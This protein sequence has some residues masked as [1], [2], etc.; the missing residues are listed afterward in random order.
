VPG[1]ERGDWREVDRRLDKRFGAAPTDGVI[2][3]VGPARFGGAISPISTEELALLDPPD[4]AERIGG[5]EPP[6][7]RSFL[8]PSAE[9]LANALTELISGNAESWLEADPGKIVADLGAPRYVSAY[10]E[11][12]EKVVDR[13]ER[14]QAELLVK[15]VADIQ[16]VS[17]AAF[18]DDRG[19]ANDWVGA[20]HRGNRLIRVLKEHGLLEQ[21]NLELAWEA[22]V[23]AV[24]F[25]G[26]GS[27]GDG[28]PLSRAINRPWSSALETAILL[29][30]RDGSADPRLLELFEEILGLEGDDAELGRAI[31]ATRLP[32]IRHVA[33]EW[34]AD[35]E[36]TLIGK[37][38]PDHL[39]DL[40]F[41]IYL[42]WGRPAETILIEQRER[43]IGSLQGSKAEF[44]LRHLLHGLAWGVEGFSPADVADILTGFPELFNE[45]A[46][47]LGIELRELDGPSAEFDRAI[48]L[49]R[50]ALARE[51]PAEAYSG[52]GWFAIN[53]HLEDST[54]LDL[55][56]QTAERE[57]VNLA[58]PEEIAERGER[59]PPDPR[60]L[61]LISLLLDADPKAWEL[62]Q[63]GA[64]GLR[65]LQSGTG[66]Q[67]VRDEL[68]ERLLERG[69]HDARGIP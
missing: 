23:A 33:P 3:R 27:G 45:A 54:W 64:A 14:G 20:A 60:V 44:A 37:Q 63:I 34:F 53:D 46:R 19:D 47:E 36:G 41:A 40:T 67:E 24:R 57:D 32:W 59:L 42:E 10:L 18:G 49:W 11:G 30:D 50:E 21:E 29:A 9:G 51:L 66:D 65:L 55:T 2:F 16:S 26:P 4:A 35:N 15:A 43:L 7:E 38:A 12:M 69:F 17:E 58:E 6:P 61:R 25:R 31:I 48:D 39:G 8:D 68:R 28:D 62:E 56:L 13:A 22:V 52:W 1:A 5:W